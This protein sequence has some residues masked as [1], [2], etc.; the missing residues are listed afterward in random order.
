MK[1]IFPVYAV[2]EEQLFSFITL[3]I[4][5]RC[6]LAW[7]VED[8]SWSHCYPLKDYCYPFFWLL[9]NDFLFAFYFLPFHS[10]MCRCGL[11]FVYLVL[12]SLGTWS[13]ISFGKLA[14]ISSNI[15]SASF[16]IL[17]FLEQIYFSPDQG[18]SLVPF[19]VRVRAWVAG[20]S[21]GGACE[22]QL[23][24]VTPT[25]WC[26]YTFVPPFPSLKIK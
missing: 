21:P 14:N 11:L 1:D 6:A 12:D 24:D 17:S 13:V 8:N 18:G 9:T 26:F 3:K 7:V 16:S 5:F 22:R 20:Q 4:S 10:G 15:A 25:Q 23:M 2:L 19:L